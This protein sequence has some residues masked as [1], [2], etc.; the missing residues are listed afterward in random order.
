MSSRIEDDM[1]NI[2]HDQMAS[3]RDELNDTNR[4]ME[5][6]NIK[7]L[8]TESKTTN[9]SSTVSSSMNPENTSSSKSSKSSKNFDDTSPVNTHKFINASSHRKFNA[10]LRDHSSSSSNSGGPGHDC[11]KDNNNLVVDDTNYVNRRKSKKSK[12][13]HARRRTDL[14]FH[15]DTEPPSPTPGPSSRNDFS[16][17]E[18]VRI[19]P[20]TIFEAPH[21]GPVAR[22]KTWGSKSNSCE[23]EANQMPEREKYVRRP[24]PRHSRGKIFLKRQTTL[25]WGGEYPCLVWPR[26]WPWALYLG[27]S[28]IYLP[29]YWFWF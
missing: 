3:L 4:R 13:K 16:K 22:A 20:P 7:P 10:Y 24:F 23:R 29:K 1:H 19:C 14:D 12:S 5:H 15:D 28:A 2:S 26:L 18:Q 17:F 21:T 6:L 27:V 9:S 25:L 8:N 11:G